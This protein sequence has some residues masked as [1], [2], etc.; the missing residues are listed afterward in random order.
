MTFSYPANSATP[1]TEAEL[2]AFVC[3]HARAC[4]GL[5]SIPT[6]EVRSHGTSRTDVALYVHGELLAIEVKRLDWRRAIYQA[7]LNRLCFD[8][9][10][11]ALWQTRVNDV[12]VR[13]AAEWGIGVL[14][15]S[16]RHLEIAI[17]AQ[18]CDPDPVVRDRVRDHVT[19]AALAT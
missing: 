17:G 3:L 7:Y 18:V 13:E 15:V 19:R 2:T 14:A 5:D 8:R 4:F 6:T 10:Y 16:E 1:A 11:I 9:S 12:V